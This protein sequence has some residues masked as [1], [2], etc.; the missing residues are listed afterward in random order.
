MSA[1]RP[2]RALQRRI[3]VFRRYR[4]LLRLARQEGFGPFVSS[5]TR[6]ERSAEATG[7]R[8]RRLLEQAGGVSVKLGQIAATRVD[9]LPPELCEELAELQNRVRARAR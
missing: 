5:G 3:N 4:E 7:L 9:L 8:L 1:P 2:F 6:V